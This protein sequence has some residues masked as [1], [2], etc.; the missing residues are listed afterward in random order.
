MTLYQSRGSVT[1]VN[2]TAKVLELTVP[3]GKIWRLYGVTMH[4]GDDVSRNMS[5]SIIDENGNLLFYIGS[6]STAAPAG[7]YRNLLRYVD[8]SSASDVG[9]PFPLPVKGGN[10]VKLAWAAG[11]TSSG[12]TAYYCVTYEEV[13]E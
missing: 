2:N 4:N 12:G 3:K 9:S 5:C 13:P 7:A 1:L 8:T 10:K 11:G 6:T